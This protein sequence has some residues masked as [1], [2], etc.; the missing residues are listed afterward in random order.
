M[1]FTVPAHVHFQGLQ[2]EIVLLDTQSDAYIGLN[3]SAATVWTALARGDSEDQAVDA[4]IARYGIA[5]DVATR[6]VAGLIADLLR[7]GLLAEAPG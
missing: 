7:R 2:E 6:D 4:L 1:R 3:P 5:D